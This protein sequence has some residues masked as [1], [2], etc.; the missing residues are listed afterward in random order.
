MIKK[1]RPDPNNLPA[2][3]DHDKEQARLL[4]I[5]SELEKIDDLNARSARLSKI[6]RNTGKQHI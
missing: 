2:L 6:M 3:L 4:S 5:E 1:H